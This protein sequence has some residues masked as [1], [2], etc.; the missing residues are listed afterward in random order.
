MHFIK[1]PVCP[2]IKQRSGPQKLGIFESL[3]IPLSSLKTVSV[4]TPVEKAETV[5]TVLHLIT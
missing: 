5:Y 1:F 4:G 3:S 2:M